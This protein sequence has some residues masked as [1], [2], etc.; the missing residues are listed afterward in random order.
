MVIAALAEGGEHPT[1]WLTIHQKVREA[2]AKFIYDEIHR[3][4][5]VL[6]VAVEV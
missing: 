3:R 5:L 2:V 1:D 4:P 6:P